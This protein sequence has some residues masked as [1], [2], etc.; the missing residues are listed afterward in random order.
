MQTGNAKGYAFVEFKSAT[1]AKI[2]AETMNNY[3]MFHRLLK[4]KYYLHY[5]CQSVIII[6]VF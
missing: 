3:L 5:T 2:V 1:V 4:C 6:F